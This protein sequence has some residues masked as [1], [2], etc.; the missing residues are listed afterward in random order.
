MYHVSVRFARKQ[1]GADGSAPIFTVSMPRCLSRTGPQNARKG[2]KCIF[3]GVY[4][5]ENTFRKAQC[6]KAAADGGLSARSGA[7]VPIGSQSRAHP[8]G[9]KGRR[10]FSRQTKMARMVPRHFVSGLLCIRSIPQ[11]RGSPSAAGRLRSARR[12]PRRGRG[13][14]RRGKPPGAVG[15]FGVHVLLGRADRRAIADLVHVAAA[16]LGLADEVDEELGLILVLGAGGM[17]MASI[18]VL[19]V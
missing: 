1:N 19:K 11:A 4:A 10:A 3:G 2:Y 8:V 13:W 6:A 5:G 17:H 7:P 9:G 18:K 15:H 14:P 12:R 16:Y